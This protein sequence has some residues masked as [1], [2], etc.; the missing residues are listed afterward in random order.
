MKALLINPPLSYSKQG[1]ANSPPLG[2]LYLA[3]ILE[4]NNYSAK[5]LDAAALRLSL[6]DL[7]KRFEIEKSDIIGVTATTLS[8]PSLIETCR[9]ARE[10]L[11]QAKI[12]IGGFGPTLESEKTLSENNFIDFVIMGEAELT[13]VQLA[14]YFSGKISFG[15]VHGIVYRESGQVKR[16]VPQE[17]ILDLDT[18]PWPAYH[19]LEPDFYHY[20]GVHGQHEGIARPNA[21]MFASRGCPHRCL[22]CCLQQRRPRFRNPVK[23]VD[24]IEF[25]HKQYGVN[26]VQIYDDEFIGMSAQQN[27]WILEICDEIIKRGLDKLGYM[28][29]GRCSRFV[30]LEILKKMRKAG[31]RWIWWGVESGSPKVLKIIQKDITVEDIKQTFSLAKKAGVKSL[32]FIMV[33][34][35]GETEEDV[36]LTAKLIKEVKPDKIRIHITTP[37]PGSKLWDILLAKNQIETFDYLKFDARLNVVHHTDEL[38]S[39]QIK[40]LYEMLLFR[41]ENGYWYFIKIIFQSFFTR[42]GRQKLPMRIKKAISYFLKWLKMK[43]S[44]SN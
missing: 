20:S 32:M 25:Y 4:K 31:F 22:F 26:S 27:Q 19:L 28:V 21:V 38:S 5:V 34:F 3:A 30:D 29:Q 8:M 42:E 12:I 13:I 10:A 7:R 18:I 17:L 36:A 6:E 24:E 40:Q 11:P 16:T 2:L 23:V 44:Y 33:G 35:P 14:D 9:L 43:K 37:L 39:R 1:G 41:F 15:E